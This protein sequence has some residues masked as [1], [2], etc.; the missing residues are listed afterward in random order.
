MRGEHAGA[1]FWLVLG[2]AAGSLGLALR[3]GEQAGRH[4]DARLVLVSSR[5]RAPPAPRAAR[6]PPRAPLD[7]PSA[8]FDLGA[9]VN[10]VLRAAQADGI[11]P[12]DTGR[13]A[14]PALR[15]EGGADGETHP[16]RSGSRAPAGHLLAGDATTIDHQVAGAGARD[17]STST[18]QSVAV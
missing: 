1:H 16:G 6:P 12:A 11:V 13:I 4:A 17:R 9:T 15:P 18:P 8:A 7:G 10:Q 5:S 14:F 2:T 3:T